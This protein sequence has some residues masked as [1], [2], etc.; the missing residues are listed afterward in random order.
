MP[1]GDRSFFGISTMP[2]FS[3]LQAEV[4]FSNSAA[5]KVFQQGDYP[6]KAKLYGGVYEIQIS[7]YTEI[8]W[9]YPELQNQSLDS[10]TEKNGKVSEEN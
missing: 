4:L 9:C 7:F 2:H 5:M 1:A 10:E 8:K 6:I 3:W